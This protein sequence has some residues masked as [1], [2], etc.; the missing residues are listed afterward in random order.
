MEPFFSI[1]IPTYNRCLMV[2]QTIDSVL[3]QS[4][5]AFEILVIDDGSTDNSFELLTGHYATNPK[6]SIIHQNNK[7]RGAARN[8]GILKSKGKYVQFLDSDDILKRTHLELLFKK[9]GELNN[10]D[11]ICSKYEFLRDGK[12][13]AT[14]IQQLEEGYYDYKLFLNGNPIACNVCIRK[15]N[16]HLNLFEEDRN[17]AI[18]EDWMFLIQNLRHNKI[19]IIDEVSVTMNDHESRSMR[20]NNNIII[21]RTKKAENWILEKVDLSYSEKHSLKAHCNYFCGIHSYVDGKRKN[22]IMY[23]LKAISL[24][25]LKPKYVTLITKLI[26][27]KDVIDSIKKLRR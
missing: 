27:G 14:D 23:T 25:G 11:F 10:P 13:V 21:E 20:S 26:I 6:V 19:Y 9:I 8:H 22:G 18:K 12:V 3:R 4:F 17:F 1:V 16:K 2:Q 24:N 15:D 5:E 7:E